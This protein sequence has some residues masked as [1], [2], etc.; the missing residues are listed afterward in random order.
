MLC[1]LKEAWK[2][3]L[4]KVVLF[5]QN[6]ISVYRVVKTENVFKNLRTCVLISFTLFPL[7]ISCFQTFDHLPC[8]LYFRF[9]SLK[10]NL[11]GR[12]FSNDLKVISVLFYVSC[13]FKTRANM[14]LHNVLSVIVLSKSSYRKFS[15][16]FF[17]CRTIYLLTQLSKRWMFWRI[18]VLVYLFA[19]FNLFLV[20]KLST[21]YPV[22]SSSC[23]QTFWYL[24][25]S[26][27]F[28]FPNLKGNLKESKFSNDSKMI[29]V[30]FYVP[31]TFRI[32]TNMALYSFL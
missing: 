29:A 23:F 21:I 20:F 7:T 26:I 32:R 12:I 18:C 5:L 30:F 8:S 10:E 13:P 19:L 28:R 9:P 16:F 17:F 2:E 14:S 4:Q 11:K 1:G 25:C 3:K 15:L 31:C 22:L 24:P 6:N 27:Y